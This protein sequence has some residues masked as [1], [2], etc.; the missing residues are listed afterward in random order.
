MLEFRLKEYANDNLT[1]NW[2][3]L[4]HDYFRLKKKT[5]KNAAR[6]T[7]E[8]IVA[9][10]NIIGHCIELLTMIQPDKSIAFNASIT[11][12]IVNQRDVIVDYAYKHD[13]IP[14]DLLTM[15]EIYL[16]LGESRIDERKYI[17]FDVNGVKGTQRKGCCIRLL[18]SCFR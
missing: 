17:H 11:H 10:R 12:I 2:H 4:K 18:I 13:F 9:H 7:F 15:W 3:A 16:P 1:G 8:I 6:T 14:L 5:I